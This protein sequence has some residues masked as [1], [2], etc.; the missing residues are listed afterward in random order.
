MGV[1]PGLYVSVFESAPVALCAVDRAGQVLLANPALEKLLG[2]KLSARRGQLLAHHLQ[3]AIVDP[4]QALCWTV[5]LDEALTLGKT[6]YL[7]LPADFQTEFEDKRREPLT[8]I[9]MPYQDDDAQHSGAVIAFHNQAL[10]ESMEAV[11]DRF[12]AAVS[13]ELGSPVNNIVAAADLLAKH[14]DSGNLKQR[15]LLEIIQ[16][17][18]ARLQRMVEQ[19][20][21]TPLANKRTPAPARNVVTL[22]PLFHRVAQIFCVRES[23]HRIVVRV[24]PHLPFVWGDEDSIQGILT[25]LLE[26]ALCY[27]PPDTEITL[28]AEERPDEILI[29][30]IDRGLGVLAEDRERL[31][32]PFYR[33]E[34]TKERIQGQG[35]GLPLAMSLVQQLGGELWY[36]Q[37]AT[38]EPRFCFTLPRVNE[39]SGEDE[40]GEGD[41]EGQNPGC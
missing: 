25:N 22:R 21:S 6:T 40:G 13:H 16:A 10:T 3:Q 20:L 1:P 39:P 11:R 14:L 30:V 2:W 19:F 23:G 31:F 36:E 34:W 7:N 41:D 24:P 29:S 15:K 12:F 28:T 35:L 8:G 32:E 17:E 33:G 26:N 38:R 27:S 9:V 5:A 18:T 37:E 4:A